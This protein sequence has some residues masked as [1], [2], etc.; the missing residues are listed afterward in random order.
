M[1][2]KEITKRIISH[3]LE[4]NN[5]EYKTSL[6][7][8][9]PQN[10]TDEYWKDLALFYESLEGDNR[11]LLF[12]IINRIQIDTISMMLG[13]LDGNVILDG[14]KEDF[15]LKFENRE[16]VIVDLQAHFLEQTEGV[17]GKSK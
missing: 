15:V 1:K 4:K 17:K 2:A 10:I 11:K 16:D 8:T 13:L 3:F 14:Q 12:E 9:K 7:N 6:K 5:H